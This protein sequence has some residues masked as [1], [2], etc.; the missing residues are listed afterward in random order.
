MKCK[1]KIRTLE[2]AG[3]LVPTAPPVQPLEKPVVTRA[4]STQ[5]SSFQK[6]TG[7]ADVGVYKGLKILSVVL[8]V[9]GL[10]AVAL[11]IMES[12]F[13]VLRQAQLDMEGI[14]GDSGSEAEASP[15]V[16]PAST[17]LTGDA[18]AAPGS[19][20]G[21][22]LSTA[23]GGEADV[24]SPA[25]S[26]T[27]GKTAGSESG[28]PDALPR[29]LPANERYGQEPS[30]GEI[31]DFDPT[32]FTNNPNYLLRSLVK[33]DVNGS[34][35]E[36]VVRAFGS[37]TF[38]QQYRRLQDSPDFSVRFYSSI[39]LANFG[40]NIDES[41][42]VILEAIAT[43]RTRVGTTKLRLDLANQL[44]AAHHE[45]VPGALHTMA[46]RHSAEI[47]GFAIEYLAN[48]GVDA[49]PVVVE[50]ADSLHDRR[51]YIPQNPELDVKTIGDISLYCL[52]RL[53]ANAVGA[54]PELMK[55]IETMGESE[56][57]TEMNELVVDILTRSH[58]Q[59]YRTEMSDW[60]QGVG[61]GYIPPSM[62]HL[63][64]Y[65]MSRLLASGY[66]QEISKAPAFMEAIQLLED[67]CHLRL[68]DIDFVTLAYEN[69]ARTLWQKR[70]FVMVLRTLEP[71]DMSRFGDHPVGDF[72]GRS[73][74]LVSPEIGLYRAREN[75]LILAT[76]D[77]LR[78]IVADKKTQSPMLVLPSDPEKADYF[79]STQH[80][81]V[82]CHFDGDDCQ[83]ESEFEYF[84]PDVAKA[85]RAL[86]EAD[87]FE[88]P[89]GFPGPAKFVLETTDRTAT[90][91]QESRLK[92]VNRIPLASFPLTLVRLDWLRPANRTSLEAWQDLV[93]AS[94]TQRGIFSEASNRV[95]PE[96]GEVND[97]TRHDV[98]QLIPQFFI[99]MDVG[100]AKNMKYSGEEKT[101]LYRLL[102]MVSGWVEGSILVQVKDYMNAVHF[103]EA[104]QIEVYTRIPT[105]Q[106][107]ALIAENMQQMDAVELSDESWAQLSNMLRHLFAVGDDQVLKDCLT[108]CGKAP[109]LV[110]EFNLTVKG[111]ADNAE[112][113]AELREMASRAL[114][115]TREIRV[116]EQ[117]Y[118]D[119]ESYARDSGMANYALEGHRKMR[120]D[121]PKIT[122]LVPFRE[123]ARVFDIT[124]PEL[125]PDIWEIQLDGPVDREQEEYRM[126]TGLKYTVLNGDVIVVQRR[127]HQ[128]TEQV[129]NDWNTASGYLCG[130]LVRDEKG[131]SSS[132]FDR[133]RFYFAQGL[134]KAQRLIV[135]DGVQYEVRWMGRN[136]DSHP[137]YVQRIFD[138]FSVRQ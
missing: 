33:V 126:V 111:I 39:G 3:S 6:E 50:I 38:I 54:V 104:R 79:E 74:L 99:N 114:G 80:F 121:P 35:M 107:L 120:G 42:L 34:R 40:V 63:V 92:I 117:D 9:G 130:N 22:G 68:S 15:S 113:S 45:R 100:P 103:E 84:V 71:V 7:P 8:F 16:G 116:V 102:Q 122:K 32:W 77:D 49:Q 83:L 69:E 30:L 2:S 128:P 47:K 105:S 65:R 41:L 124:L 17:T 115:V 20:Q 131:S 106:S 98:C 70:P 1:T 110:I 93:A 136:H 13:G 137:A 24:D 29:I 26:E 10:L 64:H 82:S 48:L 11:M 67:Q 138:S 57:R 78:S 85:K 59:A 97:L 21:A 12:Q 127:N 19:P 58:S 43:D 66:F 56:L 27:A 112:V 123:D 28:D 46:R 81:A 62:R 95:Q 51:P 86:L 44:L 125:H 109:Q 36:K 132:E 52:K 18:V 55:Q 89:L 90:V 23:S 135:S 61:L 129:L 4:L 87:Q 31:E 37:P 75:T 94:A 72:E 134:P 88:L 133:Q 96:L 5:R 119:L 76:L 53:Q 14:Q 108:V 25:G 91:D 60:A 118:S 101:N 73:F